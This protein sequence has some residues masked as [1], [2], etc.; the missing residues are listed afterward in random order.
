MKRHTFWIAA[1]LALALTM[2]IAGA[3]W[4]T[5]GSFEPDTQ[6]DRED[7]RMFLEADQNPDA[8]H[9]QVYFNAVPMDRNGVSLNPNVGR[10]ETRY[11]PAGSMGFSAFLG[12]W[13]DCNGDDYI[14]MAESALFHYRSELLAP[15]GICGEGGPFNRGGWVT[16]FVYIARNESGIHPRFPRV[17]NDTDARVWGDFGLPG[18]E[19]GVHYD[20]AQ[21]PFPVGTFESTGGLLVYADCQIG[22]NVA[23]TINTLDSDG[24]LG[25]RFED[26]YH[27]ERD[28]DSRLNQPIPGGMYGKNPC[29]DETGTFEGETEDRM[30]TVWDCRDGG[31]DVRD[32][33]AAPGQRGSL[34]QVELPSVA[35][36]GGTTNLSDETGSYRKIGTPAPSVG[37][38]E[39]SLTAGLDNFQSGASQGCRPANYWSNLTYLESDFSATNPTDGK[40]MTDFDFRYRAQGYGPA[41]QG[42]PAGGGVSAN[43]NP[44][45]SA[46]VT[47]LPPTY[48]GGTIRNSDLLPAPAIYLTFYAK[49]GV[50]STHAGLKLP[51]STPG[52]YGAESCSGGIGAGQTKQNG[53]DCDPTHWWNPEMGGTDNWMGARPGD[54]YHLRDTDCY[55]GQLVKGAPVYASLVL[56]SEDGPCGVA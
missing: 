9:K 23:K 54:S 11:I 33:T 41:G 27:P 37:N 56:L 30:F 1:G 5:R 53:W 17:F 43:E 45:W 39:G 10:L 35:G 18:K 29:S 24:A 50:A 55:D 32:P 13:K 26:R 6:Q 31:T 34:S 4:Y 46:S 19:E 12:I 28:C 48:M 44:A 38:P 8:G 25:L 51:S 36:Y 52:T 42:G 3:T 2:P 49:L 22:Y 47:Y 21:L 7:G 14:G 16:E 20:C 15:T 40:R